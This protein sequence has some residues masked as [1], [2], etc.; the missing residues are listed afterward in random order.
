MDHDEILTVTYVSATREMIDGMLSSLYIIVVVLVISASLLAF[1][2]IY[3]LNNI[4]ISERKREL[5]TIKLL[6]FYDSEVAM[7][8]YR[9]NIWLTLIGAFVGI[10]IGKVLH[11]FII[12]TVQVNQ[13][14]F[15]H[16]ISVPSY[17][18]SMVLAFI[19]SMAVN[20]VMYFQLK[21]IDM[22]ESLK[23]VE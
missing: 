13:V 15:G 21:K 7:Y 3:N 2:V 16:D 20:A 4:N 6:G 17:I 5:A 10:F 18:Y 22:I 9:E 23:S 11:G 19:F 14:M 12:K 1:V 8:V